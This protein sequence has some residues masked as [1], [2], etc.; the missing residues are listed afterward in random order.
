MRSSRSTAEART[1]GSEVNSETGNGRTPSEEAKERVVDSPEAIKTRAGDD[2]AGI[3]AV[4]SKVADLESEVKGMKESL[5]S[6]EALIRMQ[7]QALAAAQKLSEDKSELAAQKPVVKKRLGRPPGKK[8]HV[9]AAEEDDNRNLLLRDISQALLPTAGVE[10]EA[11]YAIRSEK[12]RD[13]PFVF[14]KGGLPFEDLKGGPSSPLALHLSEQVAKL[15]SAKKAEELEEQVGGAGRRQRE[16]EALPMANAS[17]IPLEA[18]SEISSDTESIESESR[19]ELLE[20]VRIRQPRGSGPRGGTATQQQGKRREQYFTPVGMGRRAAVGRDGYDSSLVGS[21]AR[22]DDEFKEEEARMRAVASEEEARIR[23]AKKEEEEEARKAKAAAMEAAGKDEDMVALCA[24]ELPPAWR[25]PGNGDGAMNHPALKIQQLW[26]Q[27][28]SSVGRSMQHFDVAAADRLAWSQNGLVYVSS[29]L[30]LAVYRTPNPYG[31]VDFSNKKVNPKNPGKGFIEGEANAA[32]EWLDKETAKGLEALY[33]PAGDF[34]ASS[35][36]RLGHYMLRLQ[37]SVVSENWLDAKAGRDSALT[38]QPESRRERSEIMSTLRQ[39]VEDTHAR[40]L[41]VALAG[42]DAL[43][44]CKTR[45]VTLGLFVVGLVIRAFS[46]LSLFKLTERL[47]EQWLEFRRGDEATRGQKEI[48]IDLANTL[49]LRGFSCPICGEFGSTE[50]FCS[51]LR[52]VKPKEA[53]GAAAA[54]TGKPAAAVKAAKKETPGDYWDKQSEIAAL[55]PPA[56]AAYGKAVRGYGLL[57]S[58]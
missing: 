13:S 36:E 44:Y 53:D 9:G 1:A 43:K 32:A 48:A 45:E 47:D 55:K 52:C 39:W 15:A 11:S 8:K 57:G 25:G 19:E 37:E 38:L 20:K 54:A 33:G 24:L 26:A 5:S 46:C 27:Q 10:D 3:E 23:L 51:Y 22:H 30:R 4:T 49:R 50:L 16:R 2:G 34:P 7:M 29:G 35:T 14:K 41:T 12:K 21:R 42:R 58:A 40:T 31:G 6:I 56:R 18:D 28:F 17:T